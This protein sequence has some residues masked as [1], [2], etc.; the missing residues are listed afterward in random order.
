MGESP[1]SGR[2][3]CCLLDAF[4]VEEGAANHGKLLSLAK[5]RFWRGQL[6]QVWQAFRLPK[7]YLVGTRSLFVSTHTINRTEGWV[8]GKI[9]A[10]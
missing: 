3:Y 10:Q 6:W 5:Q 8:K 2:E 4:Q 1:K 9:Y 7:E